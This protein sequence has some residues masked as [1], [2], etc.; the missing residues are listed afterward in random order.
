[1]DAI[2]DNADL[3]W[4]GFTTTLSLA[5]LSGVLALVLG[6]VLGAF[7]VSP[8]APLRVF[9]AWYVETVRTAA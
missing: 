9:G 3:Y 8:I 2:V 7:R 5:L 4:A 6:T 1:M